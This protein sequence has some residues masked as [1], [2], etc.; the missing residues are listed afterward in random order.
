MAAA[1]AAPEQR[2]G[3]LL[4]VHDFGGGT[5]DT[6]LVRVEDDG[7]T[8]LGYAALDDC[9]GRD[10]DAALAAAVDRDAA[11][12]LAP[13]RDSATDQ[14]GALRLRLAVGDLARGVKHQLTD[15]AE[16]EEFLLPSTPA[17]KLARRG[18]AD[19]VAPLMERTVTCCRDLLRRCGVD[20]SRVHAVV[21]VGGSS[22]MPVVTDTLNSRLGL[23]LRHVPDPTLAVVNGAAAWWAA[24]GARVLPPVAMPKGAHPLSWELPPDGATLL[25]WLVRPGKKYVKDTP[26]AR[27]RLADGTLWNLT[28]HSA[29]KLL[30]THVEPGDHLVG[31]RWLAVGVAS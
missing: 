7:H 21:V 10:V 5:F 22:R 20:Q 23:P 12:W 15:T 14:A 30:Q 26:L 28:A 11:E 13:L 27:V 2:R 17:F 8:V 25:R 6:A 18:L 9:G 4:L 3:E 19:L 1:R 31:G 24:S 29:G 16:A